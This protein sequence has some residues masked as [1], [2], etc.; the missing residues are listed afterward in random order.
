MI[1]NI[2]FLFSIYIFILLYFRMIM[3][4]SAKEYL[5]M[6]VNMFVELFLFES[7]TNIYDLYFTV[8]KCY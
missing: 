5:Y 2:Y 6:C 7:N 1:T 4:F 3:Q 8:C